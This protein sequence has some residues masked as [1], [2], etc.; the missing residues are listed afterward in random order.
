MYLDNLDKNE[1]QFLVQCVKVAPVK[2]QD[3]RFVANLLDK[4]DE[5]M[6]ADGVA[7]T[8]EGPSP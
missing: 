4:L 7:H 1:I 3:A 6:R 2:G 5:A 8:A